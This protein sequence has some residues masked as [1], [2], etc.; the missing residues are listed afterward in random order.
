[1]PVPTQPSALP[2]KYVEDKEKLR[3]NEQGAYTDG[4]GIPVGIP[5]IGKDRLGK[6]NNNSPSK[7]KGDTF[8]KAVERM[9]K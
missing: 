9:K 4:V 5:S 6:D 7:S 2:T 1:M 3:L 8:R